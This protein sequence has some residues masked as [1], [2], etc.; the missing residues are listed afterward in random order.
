MHYKIVVPSHEG[1]ERILREAL[2]VLK[3]E[4]AMQADSARLSKACCSP[5][6]LSA[7]VGAPLPS[8]VD[9]KECCT[10]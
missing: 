4:K 5:K 6:K 8:P 9:L 3:E 2:A 7:L 10:R 1:A